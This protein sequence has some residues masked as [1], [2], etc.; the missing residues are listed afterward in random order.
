[1]QHV[2]TLNTHEGAKLTL[3]VEPAHLDTLVFWHEGHV[4]PEP[5]DPAEPVH[6]LW[7]KIA[8]R[9]RVLFCGDNLGNPKIARVELDTAY[10]V[11]DFAFVRQLPHWP[12][13]LWIIP[14]QPWHEHETFRPGPVKVLWQVR[15]RWIPARWRWRGRWSPG[16][17]TVYTSRLVLE[18]WGSPPRVGPV[19]VR[20]RSG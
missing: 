5:L 16:W 7:V 20:R 9:E 18:E 3:G 10:A 15:R 1:M 11:G 4:D 14:P 2:L 12:R 19:I 8:G 13:P 6:V 17:R